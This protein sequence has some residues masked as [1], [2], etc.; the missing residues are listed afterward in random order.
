[1]HRRQFIGT[2]LGAAAAAGMVWSSRASAASDV[3]DIRVAQ[4]GFR[5][6]GAGH[7]GALGK[8]VVALCDVDEEVLNGKAAE[9]KEKKNLT[10]D[11]FTDYRKLL[12]RK[13]IDAVSIAT[14]NHTHALIA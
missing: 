11:K 13:D 12:E 2:T 1:M 9:L 7:I 4:I 6:Q 3:A 10:V 5:G 14:P 8:H